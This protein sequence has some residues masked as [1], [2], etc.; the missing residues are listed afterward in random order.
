[1]VAEQRITVPRL[2]WMSLVGELHKR[3]RGRRE[4]GAFLAARRG[5]LS[6]RIERFICYD[7]LDPH[8]LDDGF[9]TLHGEGMSKLWELCKRDS[10][11]VLAD[12]HTHP[13]RDTRQSAIDRQYPM[14]PMAGHLAL[15]LPNF[16]HTSRWS[17]EG[18]GVH[19]FEGDGRWRSYRAGQ[20]ETPVRLTVW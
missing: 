5:D 3:G 16:G 11:T 19:V 1:M 17:L 6:R 20:Q 8:A 12:V 9:V 18:V 10:L 14:V 7:D 4:S 15:I 2:T 13:G